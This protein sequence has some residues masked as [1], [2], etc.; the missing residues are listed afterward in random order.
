IRRRMIERRFGS[1]LADLNR[2]ILVSTGFTFTLAEIVEKTMEQFFSG[3]N[4]VAA[5]PL[6]VSKT[7][8]NPDRDLVIMMSWSGTTS[9]MIDAAARMLKLNVLMV[10]VTEKPFSD[11]ALVVRKSVGVIPVYSGE[12]VTVA[13]LKSAVCMLMTLDLFCIWLA[14]GDREADGSA[15]E[16]IGEMRQIP[17]KLAA[18][19]SDE[20]VDTFCRDTALA[21]QNTRRH[22]IMDAFHDIGTA[23]TGVLN[24]EVNAWTSMGN[25][26]DYSE[27]E[28][29]MD[30]SMGGDELI[31]INATNRKRLDEAMGVMNTLKAAKR[32][33]VAACAYNREQ[34]EIEKLADNAVFIP[35]LPDYFQPFVDLTFM[36]LFGFYYGLAHGRMAG[37]MPR[38]MA[39]SVTAGRTKGGGDRTA[40]DILDELE[41]A[42]AVLVLPDPA[43]TGDGIWIQEASSPSAAGYY[44]DLVRL[45]Q[46]LNRPDPSA[47]LFESGG[48]A[49]FNRLARL[50]FEHL[51]EDGVMIFVPMDRQAE[52][53]C[54]NF[55]RLWEPLLDI[56][57]QLEFPQKLRGASTEDSLVVTVASEATAEDR[58][59]VIAG[60]AGE[61]LLWIGPGSLT[62]GYDAFAESC[63]A[64]FLTDRITACPHEHLYV[65]LTLFF[66][67]AMAVVYPER[68]ERLVTHFRLMAPMLDQMLGS[69]DLLEQ[70]SRA[71]TEN[72]GY[73][74]Q[75][76][77]SGFRGNCTSW[78]TAADGRAPAGVE[79]EPFGVSAY[80]HLVLVDPRV[81]EKF[82]RLE[83]REIML[84]RY[85]EADI[86][87][88]ER[89]YLGGATVDAFLKE[90]A[91]PRRAEA[92]L[93]FLID[94]QWYLP[95][96]NP[97]YDRK[98]DC[99]VTIDATSAPQFDSALDELATFGSRYARTVVITQEGFAGSSRD[100]RLGNL[101]KYPLGHLILVP[102]LPDKT[103]NP[104]VWPDFLMPVAVNLVG[105]AM[106]YVA[107]KPGETAG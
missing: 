24:L 20:A 25:A 44:R 29:F 16:L 71:V 49:D 12:E 87:S 32:P 53:A 92:V 60:N 75:L 52:A 36:F 23:K 107:P 26:L 94:D 97:L 18:L 96:L 89:R 88:W 37:E 10:G 93:P 86:R 59:S 63:G 99:L 28:E 27:L 54:R 35:D 80:H 90:P 85:T 102:G 4:I 103:G 55:I 34:G 43:E 76:F 22:Y 62:R 7:F 72:Q 14:G 31:L 84:A 57:L 47:S 61:H 68:S 48:Q 70:V 5:T 83:S 9:D 50:I 65:A 19:L 73:E 95:V 77:V 46:I 6:E 81:P 106:T 105:T 69:R 82:V 11:L 33:F 15:V 64:C 3:V 41:E 2:I 79:C 42:E 78:Q 45:G 13:P 74:K 67:R 21:Y 98:Q 1:N 39:K 101:K 30:T 58:L 51:A 100:A 38:N 56:P 8:I 91:M 66:C 40:A 104:L 17:D